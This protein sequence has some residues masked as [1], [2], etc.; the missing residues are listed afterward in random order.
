MPHDKKRPAGAIERTTGLNWKLQAESASGQAETQTLSSSAVA[1]RR[2]PVRRR[3]KR[4][5]DD[6]LPPQVTAPEV[7]AALNF[8]LGLERCKAPTL[9]IAQLK[10]LAEETEDAPNQYVSEGSMMFAA[11]LLG[12]P[13]VNGR[14][15]LRF[16]RSRGR[17]EAA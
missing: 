8:L 3:P 1:A 11:E 7:N 4:L 14:L 10:H 15:P 5:L 9:G 2:M 16:K 6:C 12:I 17:R 13:V